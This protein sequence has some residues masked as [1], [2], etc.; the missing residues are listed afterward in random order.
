VSPQPAHTPIASLKRDPEKPDPNPVKR[1]TK[2]LAM[3][4]LRCDG[5]GEA[6]PAPRENSDEETKRVVSS[7]DQK[8]SKQSEAGEAITESTDLPRIVFETAGDFKDSYTL[9][10]DRPLGM[11]RSGTVVEAVHNSGVSR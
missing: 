8:R 7:D 2:R 6:G 11:G 4:S 5:V 1:L 10:F 9:N 3:M